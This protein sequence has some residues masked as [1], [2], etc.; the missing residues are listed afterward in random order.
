M[1][2]KYNDAL[3]IASADLHHLDF[4]VNSYIESAKTLYKENSGSAHLQSLNLLASV[5]IELMAKIILIC[6]ICEKNKNDFVITEK[7]LKEQ[8]IREMKSYLHNLKIIEIISDLKQKL[9][10]KK[11]EKY[12]EDNKTKSFVNQYNIYFFNGSVIHIKDLE[13]VRYGAFATNKDIVLDGYGYQE[14]LDFL[15][16]FQIEERKTLE[17]TRK[18]LFNLKP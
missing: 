14:I 17:S 11:I 13:A 10:I 9:N 3:L 18:N 1:N 6:N 16:K 8:I 4:I 5:S 15:V 7:E 12:P 2:K